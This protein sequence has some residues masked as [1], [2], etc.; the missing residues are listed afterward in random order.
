MKTKG[1]HHITAMVGDAQ[2]NLAFYGKLL[3]LRFVKKTVNFD[4][5]G[6]YHFYFGN[7]S[8]APGT[9]ITFFP[10]KGIQ[11]GTVGTGQVG[12]TAYAIPEGSY[13][14]WQNRLSEHGVSYEETERFGERYIAFED[15]HGL[16]IELV[17]R[18]SGENSRYEIDSI[19]TDVALKGFAG[20]T[21]YSHEPVETARLL[22]ETFGLKRTKRTETIDR[23]ESDGEL[24]NTVDVA[25]GNLPIGR[26]G[27]GTVHH[28]AW[29]AD[30]EADQIEWMKE[31][32]R[33]GLL[34]TEVKDR[35]YF[36]SIYFHDAGRILHE[37]ATDTPGF[38]VDEPFESLGE[39]LKLPEQF[40]V[41][42]G[43]IEAHVE[44]ITVEKG[45]LV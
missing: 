7:E 29:R 4:D 1:I 30:D 10:F 5:P 42:R 24:G 8:G 35:N 16:K 44:P 2:E 18:A 23:Y 25:H 41:H 14:F 37:I 36:T 26:P 9:I 31:V 33:F 32:N 34:T 19:T 15:P 12:V 6:T 45:T 27:M 38:D 3:G 17:E 13:L 21:L 28:I 20:A 11:K 40:E 43:A 39:S 22:S